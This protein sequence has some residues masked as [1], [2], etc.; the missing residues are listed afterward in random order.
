MFVPHVT[1][2]WVSMSVSGTKSTPLRDEETTQDAKCISMLTATSARADGV[3]AGSHPTERPAASV[4]ERLSAG[5]HDRAHTGGRTPNA[6]QGVA[7]GQ[8]PLSESEV[9]AIDC[10]AE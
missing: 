7:A 6:S 5:I 4:P 10:P 1:E 3:H 8:D 9:R 2:S